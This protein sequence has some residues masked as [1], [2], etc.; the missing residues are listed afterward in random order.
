M[1]SEDSIPQLVWRAS[2]PTV[3]P[4]NW[5]M[6]KDRA[7]PHRRESPIGS[8]ND[9][10]RSLSTERR[11][12]TKSGRSRRRIVIGC[13]LWGGERRS[14]SKPREDS[15]LAAPQQ[16]WRGGSL[17]DFLLINARNDGGDRSESCVA[18]INGWF[19]IGGLK[20]RPPS[21]VFRGWLAGGGKATW[22]AAFVA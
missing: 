9:G 7:R 3:S 20:E 14:P 16:I 18:G 12:G 22:G 6:G 11:I 1:A 21:L 5:P 10:G 13:C 2:G 15:N 17:W 19:V 8:Q 4:V